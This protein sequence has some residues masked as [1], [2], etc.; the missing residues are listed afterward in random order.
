M[1]KGLWVE[2]AKREVEHYYEL[3]RKKYEV[4]S[5]RSDPC[6]GGSKKLIGKRGAENDEIKNQTGKP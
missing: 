2:C 6:F 1:T 5:N 3:H 4:A